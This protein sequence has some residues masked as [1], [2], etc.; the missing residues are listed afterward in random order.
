MNTAANV[1]KLA[2]GLMQE[3]AGINTSFL[4]KERPSVHAGINAESLKDG[5]VHVRKQFMTL[6]A[7][8]ASKP[9]D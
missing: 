8:P 2:P 1:D 7:H 3:N 4:T 6:Q 9:Q 5:P